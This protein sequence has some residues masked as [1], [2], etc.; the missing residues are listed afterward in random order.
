MSRHVGV[1]HFPTWRDILSDYANTLGPHVKKRHL[2]KISCVGID[3]VLIPDKPYDPECLSPVES[4]DR[5]RKIETSCACPNSFC[6]I[7]L[8]RQANDVIN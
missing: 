4:I 1:P 6:F 5:V 3:P 7:Q 8:T 2:E